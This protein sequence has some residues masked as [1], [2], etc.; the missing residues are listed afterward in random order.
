[1]NSCTIN[2]HLKPK[3]KRNECQAG[4]AVFEVAVTSAPVDNKANEHLIRLLADLLDLPKSALSIIKGDHSR[5]KV[6]AIEGLA[7]SS[8]LEKLRK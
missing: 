6:I 7:Y 2:V 1:M 8:V 4:D 5:N 3:A